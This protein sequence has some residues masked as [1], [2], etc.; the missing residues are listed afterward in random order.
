[1]AGHRQKPEVI[2]YE[3]LLT[4]P[5]RY[6]PLGSKKS[7]RN[8]ENKEDFVNLDLFKV[9]LS[10][11]NLEMLARSF[12]KIQRQNGGRGTLKK[13]R[14]L[15][16]GRAGRFAKETRMNEASSVEYSATGYNNQLEILKYLNNRF[17]KE[18]C[19]NDVSWN[20]LVPSRAW[21]EVGATGQRKKKQYSDLTAA[22]IPTLDVWRE[23]ETQIS[24]KMFRYGNKIPVWQTSMHTRHYDRGND[25]FHQLE[26]DRASL[27]VPVRPYA[28]GNIY[29]A[30][31]KWDTEAWFGLGGT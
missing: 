1:M 25:G 28:M 30:L 26:P 18:K 23:Q 24:N 19:Y 7:V 13:C 15:V 10:G 12:H 4:V 8:L 21:A 14:Q 3:H 9:F 31:D 29:D 27:D 5:E 22:D 17:L 11:P 20:A 16:Q 2:P 6:Q